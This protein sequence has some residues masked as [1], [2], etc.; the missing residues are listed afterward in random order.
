MTAAGTCEPEKHSEYFVGVS[1]T[2]YTPLIMLRT[3][4]VQ[5]QNVSG[6]GPSDVVSNVKASNM[7]MYGEI[8][9]V[10]RPVHLKKIRCY[11][12]IKKV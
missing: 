10:C 9:H 1:A 6:V 5:S 2:Y 7:P 8:L 11:V 4:R 3:V 12:K